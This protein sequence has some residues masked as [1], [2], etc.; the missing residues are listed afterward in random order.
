VGLAFN[1]YPIVQEES[2]KKPQRHDQKFFSIET[3]EIQ[4]QRRKEG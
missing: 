1:R 4:P 3:K 2:A